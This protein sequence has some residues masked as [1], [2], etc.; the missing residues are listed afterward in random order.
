MLKFFHTLLFKPLCLG[1][2]LVVCW[3]CRL[4]LV[5]LV[6]LSVLLCMFCFCKLIQFVI[7]I[8]KKDFLWT[9]V[10]KDDHCVC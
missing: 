2:Y 8:Q 1:L 3:D 7:A 6:F 9:V 5:V 4:V 10:S